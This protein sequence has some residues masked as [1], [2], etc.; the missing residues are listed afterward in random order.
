MAYGKKAE[1]LNND[2]L[3]D[4]A[5]LP[6]W[7]SLYRITG[8][9]TILMLVLIPLQIAVFTIWSTP[10]SIKL[11]FELFERNWLLGLLH[12][13]LLYIINNTIVA[14]MYLSLY[15]SLRKRNEGLTLI[16]L[17]LGLL[18][19][20]AYYSSN[21]AFEMLSLSQQFTG[22][23]TDAQRAIYLASGQTML[24]Q[25]K[26]TAFDTYY[27][28]NALS[29][30]VFAGVMLKSS[31]YSRA[32]ACIGLASGILMLIPSTAGALGLVFSLA[33]LVPWYIFSI[34]AAKRFFVL[35]RQNG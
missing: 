8:M 19:I 14:V 23:T 16:A 26:G 18:G 3:S 12:S 13:D 15:M 33:S 29:L 20:A 7:A 1:L 32:T 5:G 9:A 24:A 2:T 35:G 10:Q 22:C 31:I 11:W 34:K 17:L 4:E 30:L 6:R 25:W 28:L 21:P 27:V